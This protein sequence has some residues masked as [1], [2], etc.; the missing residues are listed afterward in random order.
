MFFGLD[1]NI[2]NNTDEFIT[3][4]KKIIQMAKTLGAIRLVFGSPKNRY[5]PES[6]DINDAHI[7]FTNVMNQLALYAEQYDII[8]CLEPNAKEYNCN[9]INNIEEAIQM[10]NKVNHRCFKMN[11]DSGNAQMEKDDYLYI[12][13]H[14][15]KYISHS[16]ISLPY[17]EEFR[18]INPHDYNHQ[19]ISKILQ[20]HN[21]YISLEMK[22]VENYN[23]YIKNIENF[24]LI[25]G[26]DNTNII[27][28]LNNH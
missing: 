28:S 27:S 5:L 1:Y 6:I 25:Y 2:F 7:I 19:T 22:L 17:L 14:V 10:I 16:Q 4:F 21:E 24:L 3:H 20:S 23:D 15:T 8:I 26:I 11:Y 13:N 9:Y 12:N 18:Y